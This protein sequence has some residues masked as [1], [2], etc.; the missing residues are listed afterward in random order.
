MPR[1]APKPQN[2][3]VAFFSTAPL[4]V[5][6]TALD[7]AAAIVKQRRQVPA[8]VGQ[9]T[10]P[11]PVVAR[12]ATAVPA[13]AAAQPPA[14]PVRRRRRRTAAAVPVPQDVP[15]PGTEQPGD[16]GYV[17]QVGDPAAA[18]DGSDVVEG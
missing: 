14:P 4:E 12:P 7:W 15:L 6:E 13:P 9:P 1:T 8:S 5:A 11:R 16:P 3:I 2:V 18:G 17:E 10:R